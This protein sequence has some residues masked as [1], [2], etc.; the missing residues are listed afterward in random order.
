MY[1]KTQGIAIDN[2]MNVTPLQ[3]PKGS[4]WEPR[5]SVIMKLPDSFQLVLHECS[6][7][8]RPFPNCCSL[9]NAWVNSTKWP[10]SHSTKIYNHL[11]CES[12]A[13]TKRPRL[14]SMI[15]LQKHAKNSLLGPVQMPMREENI[16]SVTLLFVSGTWWH[17]Y[18]AISEAILPLN[19]NF[20]S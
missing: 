8:T 1:E 6:F 17:L 11:Y 15:S 12:S 20:A 3:F 19:R 9:Q 18:G 7:P 16:I 13:A 14:G 10:F 2:V 5:V 4:T